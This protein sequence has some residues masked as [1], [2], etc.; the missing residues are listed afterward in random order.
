MGAYLVRR[1]LL[2]VPTMVI[3]YTL[4]FV[5]IHATPG[6]PWDN[7]EK[8]LAPQVIANL[9]AKYHMDAP[10]W[11]QYVLYLGNALHGSLG[12]SYVNTSQ[13]VS[14]IIAEFFPVSMQLGAAAMVFAIVVGIPLGTLAA[15]YRNTAVDYAATGIVVLGIS[16]PNYVMATLLVTIFAV[17]LH[18][19][20]T[21]GWRGL[22]DVRVL[23]PMTAIGFRP[24]TT[25][26]R[27]LR[28][29]LLEVLHQDYIR[30]ARAKGLAGAR[31]VVRHALRNA[32]TPIATVSGIL[33]ADVVTGSFFVET[34]TRVPGIGRYF[35]TATTGRDY[36]VLLALALLFA[37]IIITM[38]ILVDLSYALLD[39]Q[40]R[41]G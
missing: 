14:E 33:V 20:P 16:I 17:E 3:V 8:P 35:V 41:Y 10:L 5:L 1:L 25:L 26:A 7:A 2:A 13:D 19:V 28:T 12:P 27:Y 18:W 36:P 23:I 32:M 4:A 30:T 15:V 6:G 37:V 21:G 31:V 11:T 24:A 40:V 39:P 29:S 34:I 22:L 38:N 9:K